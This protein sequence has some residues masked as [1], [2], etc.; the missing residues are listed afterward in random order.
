MIFAHS[1]VISVPFLSTT[2]SNIEIRD[3]L[4]NDVELEDAAGTMLNRL[5]FCTEVH[6]YI[7]RTR[8]S[9]SSKC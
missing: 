7:S 9:F 8:F 1:S 3:D 4:L 5:N 6:P 2:F